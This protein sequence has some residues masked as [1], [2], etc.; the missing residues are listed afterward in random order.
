MGDRRERIR[1]QATERA[2][3]SSKRGEL[4]GTVFGVYWKG[5]RYV[6]VVDL[7]EGRSVE[8][9]G[10]RVRALTDEAE[11]VHAIENA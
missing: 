3:V 2:I 5:G 7:D 8:V 11:N 10:A 6:Y 9:T 1:V 4:P